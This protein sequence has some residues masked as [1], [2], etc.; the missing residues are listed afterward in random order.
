M[1][2]RV[3]L[4][5]EGFMRKVGFDVKDCITEEEFCKIFRSLLV[6]NY[7]A[8]WTADEKIGLV[9][10]RFG[11]N[12][13]KPQTMFGLELEFDVCRQRINQVIDAVVAEL[14]SPENVKRYRKNL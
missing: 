9:Y 7:K 11:F 14:R 12:K 6:E 2:E 10:L 3:A 5:Y 13:H 8:S 4:G 1:V